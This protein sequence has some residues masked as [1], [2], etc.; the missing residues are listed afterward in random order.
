MN[1]VRRVAF[2]NEIALA[3]EL[4]AKANSRP[5]FLTSSA[6][7]LLARPSSYPMPQPTG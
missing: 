3:K 5:A 7:T 4:I 2:D 6:P 1:A